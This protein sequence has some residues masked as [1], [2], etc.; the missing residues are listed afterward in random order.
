MKGLEIKYW[1]I[2]S[3]FKIVEQVGKPIQVDDS[4]KHRDKLMFPRVLIEVNIGQEFV[5]NVSFIDEFGAEIEIEV[6]YEWIPIVCNHCS[7]MGHKT[8]DC[9]N[10]APVKQTWVPK[11]K[12]PAVEKVVDAEGFQKVTNGVR[13]NQTRNEKDE[14]QIVNF[15][16]YKLSNLWSR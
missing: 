15:K 16:L 12:T 2:K 5:H 13:V 8:Q 11:K 6:Q 9:R 7:G 10:K 4:T 14:V 3:L 1:G